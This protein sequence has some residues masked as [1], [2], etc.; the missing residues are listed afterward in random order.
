MHFP[1]DIQHLEALSARISSRLER[2]LRR[3][4]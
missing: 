3:A 4:A 2:I 1:D